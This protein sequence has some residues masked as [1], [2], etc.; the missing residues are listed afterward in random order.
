[1]REHPV[2]LLLRLTKADSF[3]F[4]F[5]KLK[6]RKIM[7][8][9]G[10]RGHCLGPTAGMLIKDSLTQV[11]Y[12]QQNKRRVETSSS[13]TSSTTRELNLLLNQRIIFSPVPSRPIFE[14]YTDTAFTIF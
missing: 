5:N 9:H 7:M 8:I 6:S 1:M 4:T 2:L 12:H 13:V 10:V 3:Y 14:T 11:G